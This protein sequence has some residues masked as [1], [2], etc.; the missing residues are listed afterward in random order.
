MFNR[1]ILATALTLTLSAASYAGGIHASNEIEPVG[2]LSGVTTKTPINSFHNTY[3]T[4]STNGN[5]SS[6]QCTASELG[7]LTG[8][9]F[10]NYLLDN[11]SDCINF[12]FAGENA[13]AVFSE[14]NFINAMEVGVTLAESYDGT[15]NVTG[16][17]MYLRAVYFVRFY[18]P[19]AVEITPS[20]AEAGKSLLDAYKN[21]PNFLTIETEIHGQL[22]F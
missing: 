2:Y 4:S 9:A 20:M 12:L 11:S 22:L 19:D 16:L 3:S 8:Q 14:S 10:V 13:D 17:F 21:I 6:A 15:Q 18:Q 1:T 5:Q 7:A